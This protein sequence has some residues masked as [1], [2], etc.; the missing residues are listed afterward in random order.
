LSE[1]DGPEVLLEGGI[2]NRGLVVRIGDT[3]RR[4]AGPWTPAIHALLR[5]L[6]ARGFDRVPEPLGIDAQGRE[7][8]SLLPGRVGTYP[9][10]DFMLS[11]ATLVTVART[12]RAY[13]D[14]TAGF[15][16]P[17]GTAWRWP[18]H[19]PAE[20]ICHNDFAPYN[21]MWEGSRLTAVI[22]FDLASPGP[23]AWDMAYAAYRFVPLTDPGNP[24]VPFPGVPEQARRLALFCSAY[25]EA[26]IAPGAVLDAA[27]AC[28]RELVAF[29]LRA[30]AAGDEEAPPL[31]EAYLFA[32]E[33]GMPPTGGIGIGIDRL[34]MVL[35]G[36]RSIREVVLFPAMR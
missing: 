12:L 7:V 1:R 32:L 11:D 31:D 23:R 2:A 36:A 5:H 10:P 27:I 33:H 34:V 21:L 22:D 35:T 30:A 8:I 18:A 9:L 3:V 13:H 17:P 14:A 20:V 15:S 28:L 25:G 29:I 16:L 4:G 6:R 24:D 26:R 19:A